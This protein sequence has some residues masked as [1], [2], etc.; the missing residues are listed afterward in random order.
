MDHTRDDVIVDYGATSFCYTIEGRPVPLARARHGKGKTYDPQK[1]TKL[2]HGLQLKIQ[3]GGRPLIKGPLKLEIVFFMQIPSGLSVNQIDTIYKAEHSTT[4]D[5][6]N[7]IKYVEDI[8][9][10]IIFKDDA[11]ISFII[12]RKIYSAIARTEFTITKLD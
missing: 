8:S 9:N 7:L 12:A 3:H 10:G 4:P 11:Q 6:S 2:G 5:L 1:K